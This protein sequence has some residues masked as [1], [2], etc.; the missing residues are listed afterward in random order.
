MEA[1]LQDFESLL[2]CPETE[3][4]VS[5]VYKEI[6]SPSANLEPISEIYE[7]TRGHGSRYL[8]DFILYFRTRAEHPVTWGNDCHVLQIVAADK[9]DEPQQAI[10]HKGTVLVHGEKSPCIFSQSPPGRQIERIA[11]A[12]VFSTC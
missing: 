9:R 1:L 3:L 4:V 7:I 10:S 5:G 11:D 2:S 12:F 6:F 8:K